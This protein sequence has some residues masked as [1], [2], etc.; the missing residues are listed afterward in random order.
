MSSVA[1]LPCFRQHNSIVTIGVFAA[2]AGYFPAGLVGSISNNRV[3][4]VELL[5]ACYPGSGPSVDFRIQLEGSRA[6]DFF[7]K[8][9]VEDGTGAIREY[10]TASAA[11]YSDIGTVTTWQWGNDTSPVWTSSDSGELH[12]L[13]LV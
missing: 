6:Q 4:G 10:L 7:S 8:V 1:L 11:S 3:N 9:I 12:R 5:Q 13:T 2:L